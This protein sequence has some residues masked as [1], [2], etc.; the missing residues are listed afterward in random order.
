MSYPEPLNFKIGIFLFGYG[1]IHNFVAL[2]I[3]VFQFLVFMARSI[4]RIFILSR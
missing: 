3:W 1:T 4:R 2:A